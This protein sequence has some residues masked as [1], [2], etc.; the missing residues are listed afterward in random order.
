MLI[1]TMQEGT[2]EECVMRAMGIKEGFRE[3]V[4]LEKSPEHQQEFA[5]QIRVIRRHFSRKSMF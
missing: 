5:N 1:K 3:K 2:K 4:I